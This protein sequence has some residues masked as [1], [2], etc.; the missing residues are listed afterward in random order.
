MSD[1][2]IHTAG[3]QLST[4][5]LPDIE[6]LGAVCAVLK[7]QGKKIVQCHGQFD[8]LHIGH[9]WHLKEAK[10]NGDVLVVTVTPD[11]FVNKG[12]HRPVFAQELRAEQLAALE[13]VDYV[14]VDTWP[15]A[16]AAIKAVVPDFYVKGPDYKRAEDDRTGKINDEEAAV[17][18]VGGVIVFTETKTFSASTLIN[19]HNLSSQSPEAQVF[20][21][22][23]K[24]KYGVKEIVRH[25][26]SL[27]GLDVLVVGET[28]IDEYQYC[29]A[30]GKSS[31]EPTLVVKLGKKDVFGGG[32]LNISNHA[33]EFTQDI[34]V[35]SQVG[36]DNRYSDF[37]AK[38]LNPSIKPSLLTHASAPTIVK[39]RYIENYFFTKLFETY[40][41]NTAAMDSGDEARF[42]DSL[43]QEMSKHELVIAVDYGHGL[44]TEKVVQTLRTNPAFLAVN[45][46]SN[47]GSLGYQSMKKYAGAQFM[48]VD[49]NEVRLEARSRYGDIKEIIRHVSESVQA[50]T[51]IVTRGKEGS[52]CYTSG[53]QMLHTPAVAGKV[54]DRVGAGDAYLTLAAMC[55]ARQIPT[56]LIGFIGNV[57]GAL[58][59]AIVGHKE[60]ITKLQMIRSIESL[61]K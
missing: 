33:A 12:P 18:A 47:A 17:Q 49:E 51:L 46:Q 14:A 11:R 5:V 37:I 23:V 38:A 13:F 16:V 31:K 32:V 10:A 26:E 7:A 41:I 52:L 34:S 53:G 20:L 55:A 35:L 42:C 15:D 8:L 60:P 3:S 22:G 50:E 40:E 36:E 58:A 43:T 59:V 44:F 39:K 4:K 25:I 30:I 21:T 45:V 19:K 57:A 1:T 61:L 29:E 6:A 24:E 56:D 27:Q 48:I 54:V 9:I 2:K 28:I